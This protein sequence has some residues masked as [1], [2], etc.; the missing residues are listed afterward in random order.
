MVMRKIMPAA[1]IQNPKFFAA[2]HAIF[3]VLNGRGDRHTYRIKRSKRSGR[4]FA[5][6]LAGPDN[7]RDYRYLGEFIG[8]DYEIKIT[9]DSAYGSGS[10]QVRV[11]RWVLDIFKNEKPLPDGYQVLHAGA[12][13]CCGRLLTTPES[14]QSGIGPI[15]AEKNGIWYFSDGFVNDADDKNS[16]FSKEKA[17]AYAKL[18]RLKAATEILEDSIGIVESEEKG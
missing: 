17:K 14:I 2:G 15:C 6:V 13:C 8:E 1:P 11:L 5:S 3:T 7:T 12:C 9:R 10:T 16:P 4:Y 18:L